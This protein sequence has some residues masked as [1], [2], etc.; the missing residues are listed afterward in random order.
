MRTAGFSS[1]RLR[2][3]TDFALTANFDRWSKDNVGFV[4]GYDARANLVEKAEG[5]EE[6]MYH[7]LFARAEPPSWPTPVQAHTT[8]ADWALWV[9]SLV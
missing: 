9:N 7:E 2:G 6:E 8:P 5:A 3:D 1:V 4:F